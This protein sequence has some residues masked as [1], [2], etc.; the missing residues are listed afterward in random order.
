[1]RPFLAAGVLGGFTTFSTF[2]VEAFGM[3]RAHAVVPGL[4]YAVSSVLL[5]VAC[6]VL[7]RAVGA[8]AFGPS[9]LDLLGDEDL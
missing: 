1:M 2:S 4:A 6:V 3:L 7:G 5:G 9:A 8:A